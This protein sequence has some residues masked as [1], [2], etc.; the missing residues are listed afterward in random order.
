[1]AVLDMH[2]QTLANARKWASMLT[3]PQDELCRAPSNT[4]F[5]ASKAR[6]VRSIDIPYSTTNNGYFTATAMPHAYNALGVTGV[7][8]PIPVGGPTALNISSPNMNRINEDVVGNCYGGLVNVVDNNTGVTLAHTEW[9]DMGFIHANYKGY[10]GIS[11]DPQSTNYTITIKPEK[12]DADSSVKWTECKTTGTIAYGSVYSLK[13]SVNV[14]VTPAGITR[15]IIFINCLGNGNPY[16]D[17]IEGSVFIGCGSAQIPNAGNAVS[18]SLTKSQLVEAGKVG[19]QRCTAMSILVTNMAAPI[20]AGGELVVARCPI[21]M[22]STDTQTVM[23]DIKALPEE[24]YWRSGAIVDGGYTWWLPDDLNSYEPQPLSKGLPSDN[25][26]VA[27]GKM[28]NPG[29]LVR[30]IAT[31]VFE[32]YTPVQLFTRDYNACYSDAHRDMWQALSQKSACSANVGHLALIAALGGTIM[33]VFGFYKKHQQVIDPMARRAV[34]SVQGAYKTYVKGTS[35]KKKAKI[36]SKQAPKTQGAK[37]TKRPQTTVA[38]Y[39][40]R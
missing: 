7:A 29:G 36:R 17:S 24:R 30:L 35:Q 13:D 14:T 10:K 27:A 33:E 39:K 34:S 40:P 23:N 8:G 16:R 32:F 15:G 9:Q 2:A 22:L 11:F 31:W 1:M 5:L 21:G 38:V 6:F 37:G 20:E 26:L 28:A 25:I 18:L 4:P 12:A 19:M 3:A